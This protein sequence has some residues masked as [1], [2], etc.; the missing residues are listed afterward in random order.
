MNSLYIRRYE[1]LT[2]VRDFGAAHQPMFGTDS[3]GGQAFA[4]VG[5]AVTSLSRYAAQQMSGRGSTREGATSKA[6][7]REALRDDLDAIIRTARALALDTPGLEDKF[8]PPRG[9]G[10]QVLLNAARAF[11][12]DAEPIAAQFIEYGMPDDFLADLTADIQSFEDAIRDQ[13]AGRDINV[14][15]AAAMEASMEAGLTAVRRL[16]AIVPNTLRADATALAVWERARRVE[17]KS[18]RARVSDIPPQD[19]PTES[20]VTA[21]T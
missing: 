8:R 17:Y 3:L 4:T 19:T 20:S 6:V 12:R 15:A 14:A 2:R 16:D 7:A 9:N 11:A 5:E 18:S 21:A 10:D 13:G 1:M